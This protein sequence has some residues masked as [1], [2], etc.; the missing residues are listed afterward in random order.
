MGLH[1]GWQL[2][3]ANG[4]TLRREA[5]F[6][7][8]FPRTKFISLR[9]DPKL[10]GLR[11]RG[12]QMGRQNSCFLENTKINSHHVKVTARNAKLYTAK[13]IRRFYGKITGNQLPV[14]FPLFFYG[15]P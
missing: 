7:L 11:G 4:Y 15:C 6:L 13:N 2:I 10:E 8:F 12:K 14:H 5:S 1:S 9:V 3:K